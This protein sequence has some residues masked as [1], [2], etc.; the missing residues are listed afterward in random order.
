MFF[1]HDIVW[2]IGL[3]FLTVL[4][5]CTVTEGDSPV[6]GLSTSPPTATPTLPPAPELLDRALE[7]RAIQDDEQA[8]RDLRAL[9]DHYPGVP[10]ARRA[11]YYLAESFARRGRWSSA[12][13]AFRAFVDEPVQD[14][15]TPPAWFWLARG[16]EEAGDW[17]NAVAAY[18]RYRAFQT[19]LEPYA[20]L[21]QAAQLQSLGHHPEATR[22]YEHA[23]AS[24][25]NPAQRAACYEKA[26]AL[27]LQIGDPSTAL[28]RYRDL[29]AMAKLPDYRARILAEA[30][31]LVEQLGQPDQSRTWQREIIATAP[32]S[33]QSLQA[34]EHL[35]NL[36]DPAL[37]P[38]DAARVYFHAGYP[39]AALPFFEDAIARIAQGD[40]RLEL[41][42]LRALT[43]REQGNFA[44]ALD[45]LTAVAQAA[46]GDSEPGRQARL[47]WIQTLG[48]SGETQPAADAYRD[49]AAAFPHDPRAPVALDRAAQLLDRLGN[50]E[51]AFQVRWELEYRYP[52]NLMSPPALHDVALSHLRYGNLD[53]AGTV[54]QHLA[55]DRQGYFH[56]LG[57]FWAGRAAR[58]QNQEVRAA[59]LFRS[60]LI[61][62]P[63]SYYGVRAAEELGLPLAP[64]IPLDGP[65][66][67]AE[68]QALEAWVAAWSGQLAPQVAA[69]GYPAEII[70]SGLVQ[71]AVALGQVGLPSEAMAEWNSARDAWE[72]DPVPLMLLARIAHEQHLPYVALKVAEQLTD[73]APTE[74]PPPPAVLQRLLF[75][76]PYADLVMEEARRWNLDPRLLYA[77]M[78]QE[79]LFNP[80]A[81]SWVGARG[82]SQVMPATGYGI[83]GQLGLTDFQVD[84][85]YRPYV[86]VRFGA[87][88]L[89]QQIK[90]MEG[91]VPGGLAA[92]NG[93]PGNAQRWAGGFRV[94]D[95]DL[96]VEG[97]DFAETRNYVKLV[98]GYYGAYRRLYA[99]PPGAP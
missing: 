14:D 24:D 81:T 30:A 62:A 93:G 45:A 76:T 90:M 46:G 72:D 27:H 74:A 66:T 68:W 1:R 65:I 84:D 18:E 2:W 28:Q 44:A 55:S 11:R 61:A 64:A 21:R 33:P 53:E 54:W 9:L 25:I 3:L 31:A 88:Y 23:A 17:N 79:S 48:Q 6:I 70:G 12:V 51:E 38:A 39:D 98:Y 19:V 59:T 29:L 8:A 35:L 58:Q 99:L 34:V 41:Q 69:Q 73:L 87:Y 36:N 26:I 52:Q 40:E 20:A 43:L 10:E 7:S 89:S 4:V 15:L 63:D 96:F 67:E 77:L 91:S 22:A 16:Y 37:S 85:L 78:R 95:A 32:E 75:P 94:T 97:I 47:D 82:L 60:A 13:E 92:Y 42:R 80:Y 5:A 86:S 49:Y 71:R 57:S 83:A 50:A 56:A